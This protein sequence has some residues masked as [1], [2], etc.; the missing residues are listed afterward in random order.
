MESKKQAVLSRKNH[1]KKVQSQLIAW[2]DA[3]YVSAELV[4][5]ISS[6]ETQTRCM[7]TWQEFDHSLWPATLAS[8]ETLAET[9]RVADAKAFVE[10]RAQLV[11]GFSDQIP[12]WAKASGRRAIFA[13]EELR[14]SEHKA[15][16]SE[17]RKAI[18]DL[19]HEDGSASFA[20]GPLAPVARKLSFG[21]TSEKQLVEAQPG[22]QDSEPSEVQDQQQA[23]NN[24]EPQPQ[25]QQ[26]PQQ[27]P[28]EAR[29]PPGSLTL[30]IQSQDAR[31]RIT[32]E[33]RQVLLNVCSG[34]TT[35]IVGQVA[36]GLLVV[37]GQW[38]RTLSSLTLRG[39]QSALRLTGSSELLTDL[40]SQVEIM[41]QPASNVDSVI[42]AW[43]IEAQAEQYPATLWQR[44]CFSS[45]FSDTAAQSMYVANQLSCLVAEKRSSSQT[46]TSASSS[47]LSSGRSWA[48]SE[49]SGR[50]SEKTQTSSGRWA[51]LKL[52]P[53]WWQLR[54][55]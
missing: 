1:L 6:T 40:M 29:L 53:Q 12:L 19:M 28:Q 16:F 9:Q 17:V 30:K 24:K 13:E 34:P 4:S 15:D 35:E 32:H 18:S 51:L 20:L 38:A 25:P 2:L 54:L 42:L 21:E 5:T 50:S 33:A 11:L 48:N 43:C 55:S 27:Q 52:S 44:D 45:V 26:E 14:A 22:V 49:V 8:A 7:L 36:K 46:L 47:K 37:P 3:K 39:T 31:F 23:Q 41:S 10:G